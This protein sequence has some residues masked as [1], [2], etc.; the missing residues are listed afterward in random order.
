MRCDPVLL[1]LA[2][3]VVDDAASSLS[4]VERRSV[5]AAL[6]AIQANI[7]R[8]V[9]AEDQTRPKVKSVKVKSV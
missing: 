9:K 6:K 7:A 8:S 4:A 2:K 1:P 3:S 5:L